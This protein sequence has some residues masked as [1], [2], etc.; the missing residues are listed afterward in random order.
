MLYAEDVIYGFAYKAIVFQDES[1]RNLF[2]VINSDGNFAQ[3]F[4]EGHLSPKKYGVSSPACKNKKLLLNAPYLVG[5][6]ATCVLSEET[7][8]LKLLDS[9]SPPKGAYTIAFLGQVEEK[10]L[11]LINARDFPSAPS[12]VIAVKKVDRRSGLSQVFPVL[13]NVP[14]FSGGMAADHSAGIFYYTQSTGMGSNILYQTSAPDLLQLSARGE[15]IDFG[16]VFKDAHGP[17]RELKFSFRL[18]AG[19]SILVYDNRDDWGSYQ[20]YFIQTSPFEIKNMELKDNCTTL[21]I[22]DGYLFQNCAGVGITR[23][24]L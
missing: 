18:F 8:E 11:F 16:T 9:P 22:D 10:D 17:L 12:G 4:K 3:I 7:S 23:L 14:G 21:G 2:L 6:S 1:D 15:K 24:E 20:S 13:T 5:T 19:S